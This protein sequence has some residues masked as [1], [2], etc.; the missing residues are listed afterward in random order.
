MGRRLDSVIGNT[1]P[2]QAALDTRAGAHNRYFV[3]FRRAIDLLLGWPGFSN[4]A[5]RGTG[6]AAIRS[7]TLRLPPAT[8]PMRLLQFVAQEFRERAALHCESRKPQSFRRTAGSRH[9]R[10]ALESRRP[11]SL[12]GGGQWL[13]FCLRISSDLDLLKLYPRGI[14]ESVELQ[15][16]E[17]KIRF[18]V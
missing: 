14:F 10:P 15:L 5:R 17:L 3:G 12:R 6:S 11:E 7:R 2:K 9:R 16:S 13:G 18:G 8:A 4:R 1:K